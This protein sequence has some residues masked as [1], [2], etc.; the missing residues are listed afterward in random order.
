LLS[1][2]WLSRSTLRTVQARWR[3]WG[4]GGEAHELYEGDDLSIR[5]AA[6]ARSSL[7]SAQVRLTEPVRWPAAG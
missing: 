1:A 4:D 2:L 5:R 6:E 7:A 3:P